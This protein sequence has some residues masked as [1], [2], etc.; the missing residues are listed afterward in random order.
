MISTERELK[1]QLKE[2]EVERDTYLERLEHIVGRCADL[3][4]I[5]NTPYCKGLYIS[6]KREL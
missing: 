6:G 5:D 4:L 3:G 2:A 1:E